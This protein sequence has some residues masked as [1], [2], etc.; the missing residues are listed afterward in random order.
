MSNVAI[1][2]KQPEDKPDV[3][4]KAKKADLSNCAKYVNV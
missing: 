2:V 3:F 1:C 4:F